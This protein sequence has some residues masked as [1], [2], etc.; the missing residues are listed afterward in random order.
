MLL[1]AQEKTYDPASNFPSDRTATNRAAVNNENA[2]H[3]RAPPP[4]LQIP[5]SLSALTHGL[6]EWTG[7]AAFQRSRRPSVP[8]PGILR[9]TGAPNLHRRA[10]RP[11][12]HRHLLAHEPRSGAL[13]RG[14]C[15]CS[16]SVHAKSRHRVRQSPTVTDLPGWARELQRP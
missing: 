9:R 7:P 16:Q 2:Q 10:A 1:R 14:A 11:G 15:A 13:S 5:P 8:H 3:S 4:L 6:T 12:A